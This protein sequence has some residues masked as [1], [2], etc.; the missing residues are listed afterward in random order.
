MLPTMCTMTLVPTTREY[1]SRHII[2]HIFRLYILIRIYN[3]HTYIYTIYIIHIFIIKL[4]IHIIYIYNVGMRVQSIGTTFYTRD[5]KSRRVE[6]QTRIH[7]HEYK[8]THKPAPYRVFTRGHMGKMCSLPPLAPL[9][10]CVSV[11][12]LPMSQC[13]HYIGTSPCR[14]LRLCSMM[15][16]AMLTISLV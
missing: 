8:H 7:A 2:I 15:H 4:H 12:H 11:R 6:N 14:P 13:Q 3:T 16:S 9:D 1:T 10:Q 5:K